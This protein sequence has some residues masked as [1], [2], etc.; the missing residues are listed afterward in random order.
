MSDKAVD[1]NSNA[2]DL[3]PDQCKIQEMRNKAVD[4]NPKALDLV[5]D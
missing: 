1:G 3:V 2:L 5:R 4:D